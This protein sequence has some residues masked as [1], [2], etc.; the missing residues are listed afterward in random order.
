M[1]WSML[2]KELDHQERVKDMRREKFFKN[3]L[4]LILAKGTGLEKDDE[5]NEEE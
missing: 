1:Q 2:D 4:L 3:M 5:N